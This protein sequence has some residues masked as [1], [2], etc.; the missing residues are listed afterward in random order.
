[1]LVTESQIQ[2]TE[3]SVNHRITRLSELYEREILILMFFLECTAKFAF[4]HLFTV[5]TIS[6]NEIEMI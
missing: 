2:S 3:H 4:R 1:M 6:S 5:N